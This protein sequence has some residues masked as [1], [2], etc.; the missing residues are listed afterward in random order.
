[1]TVKYPFDE[2][3][4]VAFPPA[5]ANLAAPTLG[6][7]GLAA[8]DDYY[9]DYYVDYYLGTPVW[10]YDIQC[11]LT[12]DGLHLPKSTESRDNTPWKGDLIQEIPIRYGMSGA[13]L[14]GFRYKQP[15]PG[16][17]WAGARF[18][19]ER[20]L[21]VRRGVHVTVPWTVGDSVETYRVTLGKRVTADSA[22]DT[23]TT[24]EVPL[25]VTAEN[26]D[27]VVAA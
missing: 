6:E 3:T 1:M 15:D 11:E 24:F 12:A 16:V 4:L 17:L 26:D 25:F 7:I 21:V 8:E 14:R 5:I 19:A 22:Q 23:L 27:A 20:A 9:T 2:Y 10:I 18:K 13:S